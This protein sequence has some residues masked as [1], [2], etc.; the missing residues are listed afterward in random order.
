MSRLRLP[1]SAV[2]IRA[3]V[4]LDVVGLLL[5][6]GI[7][8]RISALNVGL[9]MLGSAL[10]IATAGLAPA[11]SAHGDADRIH[12]DAPELVGL[13]RSPEGVGVRPA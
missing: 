8:F 5:L 12:H 1:P 4:V 13:D 6:L 9:F 10:L 2:L 3:A 7:L 11:A